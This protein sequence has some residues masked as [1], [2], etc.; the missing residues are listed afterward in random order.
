MIFDQTLL[1]SDAQAITASAKSTNAIDL[2]ATGRPYGASA[3]L[4][5]DVGK[6]TK[7]PLLVQVVTA[8]DSV[9]DDE[10]LTVSI[11]LDSTETFTPDKSITLGTIS[12]AYLKKVGTQIPF[13][14]VPNGVNLRYAQLYY[15]VAGTGN[16]TA[17]KI[18][19]GIV[20]GVQT[21]G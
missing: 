6:G 11:Q 18:T 20:M 1:F 12:N 8:F 19:A 2:G 15:T 7:I 10:T 16:F 9:A 5:R 14:V 3:D 13:D 4:V 21:N 17:G